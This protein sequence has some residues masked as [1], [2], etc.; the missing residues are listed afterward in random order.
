MSGWLKVF[1]QPPWWACDACG[2]AFNTSRPEGQWCARGHRP[3]L[4]SLRVDVCGHNLVGQ[5]GYFKLVEQ[6]GPLPMTSKL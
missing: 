3:K 4:V 2:Q 5:W 6:I 1:G